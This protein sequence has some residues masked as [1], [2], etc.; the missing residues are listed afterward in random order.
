MACNSGADGRRIVVWPGLKD[1]IAGVAIDMGSTTMSA[2]LC[3]MVTG[4]VLASTG[5]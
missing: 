3:D 1:Q 4:T 2:H 5:R